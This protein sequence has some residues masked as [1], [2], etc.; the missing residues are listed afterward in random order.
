MEEA[1]VTRTVEMLAE[2]LSSCSPDDRIALISVIKGVLN[3]Q[4]V[5]TQ[6]DECEMKCSRCGGIEF[7]RYG[8]TAAGSQRWQCKHCQ[9]V[10]CFNST[11]TILA[12]TKLTNDQWMTY[13]ECFVDHLPS[14]RVCERVGVCPKTAWFMRIR[15]L[16]ALY[17]YLPAFQ[18]RSGMGV[19]VDEI[20]FRESFKGTRFEGLENKPRE[21]RHN[22]VGSKHGISDDQICV[23]TAFDDAD[24]FFFEVT[25]RGALTHDIALDTLKGRICSGA[26]V[27]T[28]LHRAYGRVMKEIGVAV[29]NAVSAKDEGSIPRMNKIHQDIRTFMAPFKGV[30]TKWL[31]LYLSWY[32]WIRT[33]SSNSM[34]AVKQIA[35]GDYIH[36][37]QSI[38]CIP[39]P[40]RDGRMNPTKC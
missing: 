10:R 27:N 1:N 29:H 26:I 19:E 35:A 34:A 21:A 3:D 14:S 2:V 7:S 30:S 11:G 16:E 23:V 17:N 15:A 31:H 37:W 18:M 22:R 32:K 9:A 12:N 33:F 40:F 4:L 5:R 8:K 20:Y 39:Y 25:C 28:D 36:T 38:K 13:A 24:D 6:I